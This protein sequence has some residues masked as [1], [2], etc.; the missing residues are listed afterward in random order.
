LLKAGTLAGKHSFYTDVAGRVSAVKLFPVIKQ[1]GIIRLN[2]YQGMTKAIRFTELAIAG[3]QSKK[4]STNRDEQG[5]VI[6]QGKCK[7]L[8][9]SKR[10]FIIFIIVAASLSAKFSLSGCRRE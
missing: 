3:G 5:L 8:P 9:L 2:P 6:K 10:R 7:A 4:K 1:A